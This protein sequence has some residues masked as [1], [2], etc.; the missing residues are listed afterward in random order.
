M[1]CPLGVVA[2]D[3]ELPYNVCQTAIKAGRTPVVLYYGSCHKQSWYQHYTHD[4][5]P[6]GN[7]GQAVAFFKVHYV[8]EIVFAGAIQRP[9][10]SA[11]F[12]DKLGAKWLFDVLPSRLE[13]TMLY[14]VK[15]SYCLK[16]KDLKYLLC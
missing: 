9:K 13:K 3:G 1:T 11:L 12:P 7:I 2:G 15:L 16:S 14:Y 8:K 5:I 10:L 4:K 6:I